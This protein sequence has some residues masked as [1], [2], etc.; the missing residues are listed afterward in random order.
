MITWLRNCG[1]SSIILKMF[2]QNSMRTSRTRGRISCTIR[3]LN[4]WNFNYSCK[5][6]RTVLCVKPAAT[7][8]RRMALLKCCCYTLHIFRCSFSSRSSR[9]LSVAN[10]IS[11][12]KLIDPIQYCLTRRNLS[13]PSDFKMFSKD[14]L[15]YCSWIMVFKKCFHSKRSMFI[16]PT[17]S[18]SSVDKNKKSKYFLKRYLLLGNLN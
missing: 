3:I 5:I 13:I 15:S 6:R 8:W 12:P 2:L 4:G 7:E 16:G 17:H 14:T 10:R 11:S 1:V 9:R 18:A